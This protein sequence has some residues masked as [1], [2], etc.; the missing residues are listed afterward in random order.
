LYPEYCLNF[1]LHPEY[2]LTVT[3]SENRVRVIARVTARVS[4]TVRVT[5]RVRAI[6]RVTA[7]ARIRVIARL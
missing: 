1:G 2:Y 3:F 7:G 6:A 4:V 5:V